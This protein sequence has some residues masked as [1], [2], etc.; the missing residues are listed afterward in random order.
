MKKILLILLCLPIIG[1]GQSNFKLGD[2]NKLIKNDI[3]FQYKKPLLPFELSDESYSL[4]GNDKL[5]VCFLDSSKPAILQIYTT[6][7]PSEM[8]NEAEN[9]FNSKQAILSFTNQM[10]PPPVNEV[11]DFRVVVVNGKKF[12]EIKFITADIQKQIS[13]L[14]FYKN[15]MIHISCSTLI[16]DFDEVFPF[17]KDFNSSLLLN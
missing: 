1:F 9:F 4:G 12:L 11:L 13:W 15:N 10:F 3:E 16:N 2:Y 7:I 17:F 14:T 6:P 5:V 8:Q